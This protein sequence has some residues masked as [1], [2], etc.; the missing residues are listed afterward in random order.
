[1][2]PPL[3]APTRVRPAVLVLL[4][5][6]LLVT[7]TGGAGWAAPDPSVSA[8]PSTTA[9]PDLPGLETRLAAATARAVA[10]A[11][12]LEQAQARDGALT[13]ARAAL[14]TAERTAQAR[15]D[16]RVRAVYMS[17]PPE[18][19]QGWQA[20]TDPDVAAMGS[21]G[22]AAGSRV[23]RQLV[24]AAAG[25]SAEVT[26]LRDRAERLSD[27]LRGQAA[28]ALVAQDGARDLL[29]QAR[30]RAARLAAAAQAAALARVAEAQATLDAAS[31]TVTTALTPARTERG[32]RAAADEE[33]VLALLEAT[34]PGYPAGYHPTG[35]VLRGIASWYGPGFVGSPTATGRPYDPERPSCAHLTLPLGTVVHVSSG[36]RST[37]CLVD[38][39]GPYVDGRILDL[40]RRGARALG[41]T[42]TAD[43]VVEVLG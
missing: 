5:T 10:L 19:M 39:R 1:M 7:A 34:G 25:R 41:F 21:L 33:P 3:P 35:L 15:L 31:A 28:A 9:A 12:G 27:D 17:A 29:A 13:E 18:L 40:S 20:L 36:D 14:A 26:A 30:E 2:R 4:G 32:R 23:D 43:V 8:A 24:D 11:D 6:A 16:A 37:N 42:G 38:D 22:R